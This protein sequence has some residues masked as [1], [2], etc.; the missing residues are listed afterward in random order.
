[1]FSPLNIEEALGWGQSQLK[2]LGK[3]EVLASAERLLG[4]LLGR[5]RLGLHLESKKAVPSGIWKQYRSLIFKRKKRVPLDYLIGNSHFWNEILE[6][7]PG[8][9]IP[10]P[11]TEV[12]IEKFFENSGLRQEQAFSFLDLGC[13]SGAIA[14]AILR[15]FPNVKGVLSDISSAALGITKKNLRHYGLLKRA[16]VIQSNLFERFSKSRKWDVILSNPPYLSQRDLKI[17]Q[18]EVLQ[19]PHQALAGGK[20]G[21]EIYRR[22]VSEAPLHLIEGGLLVLEMGKGQARRIQK[23]CGKD[24]EAIRI[25]KDYANMDRVLIAKI[26]MT[27]TA[28]R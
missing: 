5:D 14:V 9:L 23:W 16:E 21:L 28:M 20:D 25:F 6:V 4:F 13:G 12:L 1:M 26:K 24:F 10:R 8:C 11:S 18:P 27:V 7:G 3:I 2:V 19:E 22:I 15:H 17:A